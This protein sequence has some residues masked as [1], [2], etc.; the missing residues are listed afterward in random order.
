MSTSFDEERAA[1]CKSL[2]E[3]ISNFFEELNG[4]EKQ[5]I[6][7]MDE[8]LTKFG[9]KTFISDAQYKWIQDI[10]ERVV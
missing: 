2:I 3:E 7:S 4:K 1:E 10:H 8:R 9:T 5:F 6:A